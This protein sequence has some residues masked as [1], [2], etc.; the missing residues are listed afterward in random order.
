MIRE[1]IQRH[2]LMLSTGQHVGKTTTSLALVDILKKR[3]AP[4]NGVVAYMK[5]VGQQHVAVGH[6]LRVDK[7]RFVCVYK[8]CLGLTGYHRTLISLKII[9]TSHTN[10]K[11][12]PR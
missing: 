8:S 10:T 3:L 1:S 12:C 6:G 2:V 7:V 4:S 9:L 5:P 11:T